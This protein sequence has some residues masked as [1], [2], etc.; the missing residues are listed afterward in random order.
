LSRALPL[1]HVKPGPKAD[2]MVDI[3]RDSKFVGR[4]EILEKIKNR[5]KTERRIALCGIGGIG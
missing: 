3:E 5:F 4:K 2:F 1:R